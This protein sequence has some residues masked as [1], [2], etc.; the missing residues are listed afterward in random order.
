MRGKKLKSPFYLDFRWLHFERANSA[1][2]STTIRQIRRRRRRTDVGQNDFLFHVL[3][4]IHIHLQRSLWHERLNCCYK[5]IPL[6]MLTNSY[7]HF[8]K[9]TFSHPLFQFFSMDLFITQIHLYLRTPPWIIIICI[10]R[11]IHRLYLVAGQ[12][13]L[14]LDTISFGR[15]L[16]STALKN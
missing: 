7:K 13:S 11:L 3:L 15:H 4:F 12:H 5:D 10:S 8:P 9:H 2:S 16:S 6:V 14:D 1:Q